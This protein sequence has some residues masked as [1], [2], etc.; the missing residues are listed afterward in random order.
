MLIRGYI[1][2]TLAD[3]M[4][5]S[6]CRRTFESIRN[7]VGQIQQHA[8]VHVNKI[9]I[10]NK[11]DMTPQRGE[12]QGHA[13]ARPIV[14]KSTPAIFGRFSPWVSSPGQAAWS[15][16]PR[17]VISPQFAMWPILTETLPLLYA[18]PPSGDDG[19]GPT[20]SGRLRHPVLRDECQE[21]HQRRE[22]VR[23]HR[24][25]GESSPP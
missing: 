3:S 5:C 2:P 25:R 22:V 1:M 11:C 16:R 12:S 24:Q 21:R 14:S 9:L 19:G 6:L 23:H 4:H 15:I 13:Q 18:R 7:W 20:T 10:G 17:V 8:D